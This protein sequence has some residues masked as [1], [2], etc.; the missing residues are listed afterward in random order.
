LTPA[1]RRTPALFYPLFSL[2][3]NNGLFLISDSE[4]V[5]AM[6]KLLLSF[7]FV[8]TLSFGAKAQDVGITSIISPVSG[9]CVGMDTVRLYLYNYS[10]FPVGGNF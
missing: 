2:I 5:L 3:R 10:T 7:L 8:F 6:R 9:C 1:I 4:T